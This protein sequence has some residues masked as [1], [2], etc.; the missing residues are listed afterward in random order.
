MRNI[1]GGRATIDFP[2]VP[3][4]KK[5]LAQHARM[6]DAHA[7]ARNRLGE[8]ER[9]RPQAAASDRASFASAIAEK[10][11]DAPDPGRTE[12]TKLEEAIEQTRARLDASEVALNTAEHALIAA[13]DAK[14]GKLLA[15]VDRD[16]ETIAGKYRKLVEETI[17]T[18]ERRDELT[19]LR[20]FVAGFPAQTTTYRTTS[21]KAPYKKTNGDLLGGS[22]L[23]KILRDDT[24]AT[25]PSVVTRMPVPEK[26]P[27]PEELQDA[28]A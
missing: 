6:R 8:L 5:E 12:T 1:R 18:R 28:V 27:T 14:R 4:L 17:A 7:A 24:S 21:R 19:S 26:L 3:Q 13:V 22:E 25:P 2:D 23:A 9:Q 20:L 15:D 16:L 11:A 10:G